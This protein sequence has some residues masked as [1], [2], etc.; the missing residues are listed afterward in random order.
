MFLRKSANLNTRYGA[1]VTR[2]ELVS[3][4]GEMRVEAHVLPPP[5]INIAA[6]H[7][8][9]ISLKYLARLKP[10]SH[11]HYKS[12]TAFNIACCVK[13][14]YDQEDTIQRCPTTKSNYSMKFPKKCH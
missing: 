12:P 4:A 1:E 2:G 5:I 9:H 6:R 8:A 13:I 3:D 11:N 14:I 10:F 7:R